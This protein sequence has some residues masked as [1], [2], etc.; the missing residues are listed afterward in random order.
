VTS[1]ATTPAT[2][3]APVVAEQAPAVGA[4]VTAE[5]APTVAAVAAPVVQSVADEMHAVVGGT[6]EDTAPDAPPGGIELKPT[7]SDKRINLDVQGADIHTVLRTLADYSGK[8]IIA[9]RTSRG[10]VTARLYDTPGR[11]P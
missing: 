1:Q 11:T 2:E 5:T 7:G 8:N 4:P 3:T 10:E 6:F 9:A